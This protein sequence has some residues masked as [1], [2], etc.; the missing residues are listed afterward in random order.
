MDVLEELKRKGA[1]TLGRHFVYKSGKHG[2]GYIDMDWIYP[3]NMLMRRICTLLTHPYLTD[4]FDTVA[5]PAV[6]GVALVSDVCSFLRSQGIN[7]AR[8]W[9]DKVDDGFSFNRAGF[10][11]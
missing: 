1:V 9:A 2:D 10:A 3:D 4:E 8:V 11:D 6:G 5:A 7:P